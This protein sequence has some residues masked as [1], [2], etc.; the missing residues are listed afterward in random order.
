MSKFELV[1]DP[2]V[3]Y[4]ECACPDSDERKKN[5]TLKYDSFQDA[6]ENYIRKMDLPWLLFSFLFF[7]FYLMM[8][9]CFT[10]LLSFRFSSPLY[11]VAVV[12]QLTEICL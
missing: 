6:H 3:S 10:R 9:V 5:S 8:I 1:F 7:F 4:F 11:A 12:E 2:I